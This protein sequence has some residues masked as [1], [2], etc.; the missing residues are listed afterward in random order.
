MLTGA[1]GM[2]GKSGT[3]SERFGRQIAASAPV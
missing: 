3:N 1:R 2:V